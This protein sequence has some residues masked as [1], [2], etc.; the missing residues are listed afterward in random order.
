MAGDA[1]DPKTRYG[2]YASLALIVL[3]AGLSRLASVVGSLAW[4]SAPV[5]SLGS[6]GVG[7]S[8]LLIYL[9]GVVGAVS[10][11][12]DADRLVERGVEWGKIRY[13]HAPLILFMPIW[14]GVYHWRRSVHRRQHDVAERG[15]GPPAVGNQFDG[16]DGSVDGAS[17]E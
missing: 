3:G 4:L 10:A 1:P 17:E 8:T 9:G 11:A 16:G 2:I 12:L 13:V 7:P 5:L 14:V 15:A 6:V